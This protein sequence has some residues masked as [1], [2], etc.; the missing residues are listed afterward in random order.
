MPQLNRTTS[1]RV[2]VGA[3]SGLYMREVVETYASLRL[4]VDVL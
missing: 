1:V 3:P 4:E 2:K